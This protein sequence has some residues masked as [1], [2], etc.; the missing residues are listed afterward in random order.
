M[1]D[2][3]FTIPQPQLLAGQSFKVR[4]RLLPNGVFG[5]TTVFTSNSITYPALPEGQYQFEIIWFNGVEDCPETLI[6]FDVFEDPNP[7]CLDFSAEV[8]QNGSIYE[9]VV[10]YPVPSPFQLPDCGYNFRI[11]QGGNLQNINGVVL[12]GSGEVRFTVP[13]NDG[14]YL[15]ITANHCDSSQICFDEDVTG[16][17]PTCIPLVITDVQ[18]EPHISNPDWRYIR[19]FFTNS[20]PRT[21]TTNI[22]YTQTDSLPSGVTPDTGTI[23][24]PG[25]PAGSSDIAFVAQP[26]RGQWQMNPSYRGTLTDIC[27]NTHSWST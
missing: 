12:T 16:V 18:I 15:R 26:K 7:A 25:L 14:L 5:S 11:Q 22:W 23:I 17:E 13:T 6:N 24:Y 2:F 8:V 27:G 9:L 1:P 21:I 20:T 10:T 3:S 4:Y 19:I